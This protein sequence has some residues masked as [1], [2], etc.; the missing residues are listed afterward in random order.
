MR[1][2]RPDDVGTVLELWRRAWPRPGATDD[3]A[4]VR[5][6]LTRDPGALLVAE[7]DGRT[8]GS[9]IAAWDGWRGGMY[10]LA[11]DPAYRRRDVARRLVA[12][13]EERLRARGAR[14]ITALVD[15]ADPRA[16]A[17][18][19]A[20]GYELDPGASRFVKDVEAAG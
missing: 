6:L 14:R 16:Q 7:L 10:R 15:G 8:V 1:A 2:G 19:R 17:V 13:G 18:W 12:D 4:A 9:L 11:V 20:A 5:A 3:E